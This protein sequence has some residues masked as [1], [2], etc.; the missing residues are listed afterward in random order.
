MRKAL[1]DIN[2]DNNGNINSVKIV[3]YLYDRYR[4]MAPMGQVQSNYY[5]YLC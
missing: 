2:R 5:Y 3:E 4:G 1:S